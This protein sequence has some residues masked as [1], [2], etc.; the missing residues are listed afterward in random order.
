MAQ[1]LGNPGAAMGASGA[2]ISRGHTSRPSSPHSPAPRHLRPSCP[3][4]PP[5][6][7]S[8]H[9]RCPR[10]GSV[11]P[12]PTAGEARPR[13]VPLCSAPQLASLWDLRRWTTP[14][15]ATLSRCQGNSVTEGAG[16]QAATVSPVHSTGCAVRV[17][18]Q[19]LTDCLQPGTHV[20]GSTRLCLT[21]F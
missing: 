10:C 2:G 1:G 4:A 13:S 3:P 11:P 5:R 8:R 21:G 15:R 6:R 17:G 7:P 12:S 9:S 20:A 16:L 14:I 19:T 18:K